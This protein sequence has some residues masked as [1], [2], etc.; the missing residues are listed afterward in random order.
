MKKFKKATS[1]AEVLIILAIISTTLIASVNLVTS[2]IRS[3]KQNEI[4]DY[5]NGILVLGLELAKSPNDIYIDD[6]SV[7]TNINQ[8]FTF[9]L[10]NE[11]NQYFLQRQT[12]V[13][14]TCSGQSV[15]NIQDNQEQDFDV[16]LKLEITRRNVNDQEYFEVASI[17]FY[18]NGGENI[19]N[20]VKG[21]RKNAFQNR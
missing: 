5:A 19:T 14:E 2:S 21:F 10:Q 16:C 8:T 15:F 11:N 20:S 1:L 9:S 13:P 4:E 7:F 12:E 17:V 3:A 18:Q 6:S